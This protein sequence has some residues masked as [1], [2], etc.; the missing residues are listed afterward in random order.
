MADEDVKR[1]PLTFNN[2][3]IGEAEVRMGPNGDFIVDIIDTDLDN[4][5][6]LSMK[7][8]EVYSDE[9]GPFSMRFDESYRIDARFGPPSHVAI[10][11]S[12][13]QEYR[14]ILFEEIRKLFDNQEEGPDA[15]EV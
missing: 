11:K 7:E 13:V 4:D 6:N 3:V 5:F 15:E 9:T 1:V 14:G 2:K 12:Q 10:K 8:I